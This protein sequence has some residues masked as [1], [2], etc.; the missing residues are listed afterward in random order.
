MNLRQ[1]VLGFIPALSYT[2]ALTETHEKLI[3]MTANT[4]DAGIL[5]DIYV[6]LGT[7]ISHG[8][9]DVQKLTFKV[10]KKRT[11]ELNSWKNNFKLN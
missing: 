1:L 8:D 11:K 3:S 6:G 4:R 10:D 9:F 5:M 2:T 7:R